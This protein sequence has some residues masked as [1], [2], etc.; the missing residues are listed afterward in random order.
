MESTLECFPRCEVQI[1]SYRAE[2]LVEAVSVA[3]SNT[4]PSLPV[5]NVSEDCR[6]DLQFY[7]ILP[8][9]TGRREDSNIN[10]RKDRLSTSIQVR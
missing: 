10:F 3:V 2:R 6:P 9:H 8:S 4:S 5:E 7:K 1:A